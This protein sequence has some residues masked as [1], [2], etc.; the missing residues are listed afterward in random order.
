[1]QGVIGKIILKILI[2][3]FSIGLPKGLENQIG[4]KQVSERVFKNHPLS[5]EIYSITGEQAR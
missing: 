5:C 2:F 1:M 3:Y 4:P